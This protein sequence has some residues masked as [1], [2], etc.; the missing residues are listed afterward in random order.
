[1]QDQV[2]QFWTGEPIGAA[3]IRDRLRQVQPESGRS[4]TLS[5][6]TQRE[7]GLQRFQFISRLIQ[8]AGFKGWVLL[9]DEVELIGCYSL[10]QRAK[11]YAELARFSGAS[12]IFTCPGLVAVFAITDDFD[13]AVLE[14]RADMTLVP[15]LLRD[16]H[17]PGEE[18]IIRLAPLGM[19]TL[20]KNG[21]SLL[22]PGDSE[23]SALY[24]KVKRLY[25]DAYS[26][27]QPDVAGPDR[28]S[29]TRLRQFVKR[30]ITEW[31][32][33]RLYPDERVELHEVEVLTDYSEDN[34]T[35]DNGG[36]G[37]DVLM[38]ELL[39]RIIRE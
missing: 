37:G 6:V 22:A 10:L 7:L 20:R 29:S 28:L 19:K 25:A 38:D 21:I 17:R 24:E 3:A 18:D 32:M 11:S 4:L 33:H 23:V 36:P 5:C 16:R 1:M 34:L 12:D 26:C 39:G 8:A 15:S 14:G 35:D 30:W 2:L 13:A 31:D 9:I 27:D